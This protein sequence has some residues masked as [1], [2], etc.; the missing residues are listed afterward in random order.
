MCPSNI[1][2]PGA[3]CPSHTRVAAAKRPS[4]QACLAALSRTAS[5]WQVRIARAMAAS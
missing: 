1:V 5:W 3:N 4:T 2:L